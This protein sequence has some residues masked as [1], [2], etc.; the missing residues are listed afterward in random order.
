[1]TDPRI[2]KA[3]DAFVPIASEQKQLQSEL[4]CLF[5]AKVP[6]DHEMIRVA[7][8]DGH[9]D[10]LPNV[11]KFSQRQVAVELELSH[12][13]VLYHPPPLSEIA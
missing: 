9:N 6:V 1:M 7:V 11:D 12:G 3:V 10:D 2:I 13:F 4:F 5:N 8:A